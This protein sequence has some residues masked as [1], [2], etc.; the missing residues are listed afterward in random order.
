VYNNK[1]KLDNRKLKIKIIESG[2]GYFWYNLFEKG[3]NKENK[4][5]DYK[6]IK[7]NIQKKLKI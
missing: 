6:A 4:S 1:I 2:W 3:W 5:T 7:R